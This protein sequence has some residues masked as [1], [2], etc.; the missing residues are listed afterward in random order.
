MIFLF[1]FLSRPT[2]TWVSPFRKIIRNLHHFRNSSN[3]EVE[4]APID[5]SL[6]SYWFQK[7]KWSTH[8]KNS[9]WTWPANGQTHSVLLRNDQNKIIN[10]QNRNIISTI[11]IFAK[12]RFFLRHPVERSYPEG[13]DPINDIVK[14]TKVFFQCQWY[15]NIFIYKWI[16]L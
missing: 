6:I 9:P 3:Y 8:R 15:N 14:D 5:F 16:K 1:Y 2:R 10:Q 7:A 12:T 4:L 13:E 11:S